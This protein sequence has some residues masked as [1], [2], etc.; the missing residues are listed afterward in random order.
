[1]AAS[2]GKATLRPPTPHSMPSMNSTAYFSFASSG[3]SGMPPVM[4]GEESTEPKNQPKGGLQWLAQDSLRVSDLVRAES[5]LKEAQLKSPDDYRVYCT[6]G[7]LYVEKGES[8]EAE[9]FFKKALKFAKAK[10][11]RIFIHFLISR[12]NRL[13]N[14]QETTHRNITDILNYRL[15]MP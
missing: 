13:L 2:C 3:P 14:R 9:Y 7:Y 5:I 10:A 15:T 6:M 12:L 4:N 8:A 1:M 11:S